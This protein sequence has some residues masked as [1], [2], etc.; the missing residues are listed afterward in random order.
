MTQ[1]IEQ[2]TTV[3]LD[4]WLWAAR[5]FKTRSLAKTAVDNGKVDV[6]GQRP[7]PSRTLRSGEQLRIDRGGEI[8]EITVAALSDVRGPAPVAQTLYV[9]SEASREARSQ[10]RLQRVAERTGYRP[11]EG[12]PDK[13]AR[14][15]ITA[16]GDIDAF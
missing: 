14:R 13:R 16:L 7:K 2:A 9:E 5:F 8:F 10:W 15:L 3:R 4:V 11:P 1:L 6:S 12:K